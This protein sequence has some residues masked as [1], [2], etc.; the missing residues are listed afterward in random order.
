MLDPA[1]VDCTYS[2]NEEFQEIQGVI[3]KLCLKWYD[4]NEHM[5]RQQ[6]ANMPDNFTFSV[7]IRGGTVV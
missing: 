4:L 3:A 1:N 6:S 2:W 7:F 5:M